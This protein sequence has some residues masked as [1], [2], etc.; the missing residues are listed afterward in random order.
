M[1]VAQLA[2]YR[3]T[4]SRRSGCPHEPQC[5]PPDA[6]DHAAARTVACHPGQGWSLLC[7]GVV[8]FDDSGEI[9]PSGSCIEPQRPEYRHH[10]A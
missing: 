10:A 3:R 8:V 7:N 2:D 1:A 9:L 4:D 6:P 5:P